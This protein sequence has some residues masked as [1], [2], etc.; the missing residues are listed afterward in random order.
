MEKYKNGSMNTKV[1]QLYLT[2]DFFWQ[3]PSVYLFSIEYQY[4]LPT[5]NEACDTQRINQY[6]L[7]EL[8]QFYN[9]SIS[10]E[11][12]RFTSKRFNKSDSIE[13][14]LLKNYS[15]KEN[16]FSTF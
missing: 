7:A 6:Y 9:C 10:L 5:S 4:S 3:S 1:T 2:F 13:I 8:C 14:F 16:I 15:R 11:T 12:L